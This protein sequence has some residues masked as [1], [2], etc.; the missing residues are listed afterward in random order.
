MSQLHKAVHIA[1][2][3]GNDPKNLKSV[4]RLVDAEEVFCYPF[5][6]YPPS[7]LGPNI[8]KAYEIALAGHN[9]QYCEVDE[10]IY[11]LCKYITI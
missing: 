7:R 3:Q 1:L 5:P 9:D 6:L 11:R 10:A 2:T 8:A 4:Q